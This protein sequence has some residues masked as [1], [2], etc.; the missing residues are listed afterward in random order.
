MEPEAAKLYV[1]HP[2]RSADLVAKNTAI[3]E[4]TLQ[5]IR[6]HHERK[7][8]SGFPNK[9]GGLQLHPMAE[10]LSLINTY[11]EYGDE[12]EAVQNEVYSHYSDRLVAAFRALLD[13]LEPARKSLK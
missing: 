5:V 4:V 6:Q 7:D 2:I 8:R 12:F 3:P 10:I 9:V 1:E 13:L 11:L